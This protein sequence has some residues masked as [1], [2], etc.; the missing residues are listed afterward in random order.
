MSLDNKSVRDLVDRC[1]NGELQG[2]DRALIQ[3]W[4]LGAMDADDVLHLIDEGVECKDILSA[5]GEFAI[6]APKRWPRAVLV[7]LTEGFLFQGEDARAEQIALILRR[8][9]PSDVDVLRLWALSAGTPQQVVERFAEAL[10]FAEEPERLLLRAREYARL[11]EPP[12]LE[13]LLEQAAR[14]RGVR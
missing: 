5:V 6:D 1:E 13:Q 12:G 14:A 9:S 3:S 4:L 2:A 10:P 11:N 7:R 8:E